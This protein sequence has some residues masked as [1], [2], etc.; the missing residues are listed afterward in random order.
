MKRIYT[1]LLVA[2]V[3][4]FGI[5]TTALAT[6]YS[7]TEATVIKA[8][9][10]GSGE[11]TNT[12]G[13][14]NFYNAEAT[15]W[16]C[17]QANISG[18]N[19][20]NQNAA[21]G[22]SY[23]VII[24]FNLS[25]AL[26]G[27]KIQ[28]AKL[29]FKSVCTVSGKNSNVIVSSIGT[30]W[31]A[32]TVTWNS[33][34]KAATQISAGNGQNV[35]TSTKTLTE[36][37][38][39][40]LTDDQDKVVAFAIYT[41][42]AREQ[43]ISDIKLTV[44]AI[45]E[46]SSANVKLLYVDASNGELKSETVVGTTGS[47]LTL[48]DAQKA[49]FFA[50]DKKYMYVSDNSADVTIASDGTSVITIS[51]REAETWTYT[52]NAVDGENTFLMKLISSTAYEAEKINV[53]YPA[54]INVEGA[55]WSTGK[56]YSNDGKGFQTSVTMSQDNVTKDLTYTKK[57]IENIVYFSE[58]ENIEGMTVCNTANA[59]V[60][61]SNAA[62]AFAPT[63]VTL[64][65]LP[66]GRYALYTVCYD[67]RKNPNSTWVFKAG[68][69]T[70]ATINCTTINY[71][72]A[73]AADF[74]ISKETDIIL[75]KG[76]NNSIGIDLI[77]IVKTGDV[78]VVTD[79]ND[80]TSY[81][82]NADLTGEG[83]FDATGT[84]G[85]SGGIVKVGNA[86]AFD[87]KQ[88]IANLPA[89]QYKVTAQAAYRFGADEA[90]EAAAITAGT[91]TKLVQLY[92]T[93][94][95]KTVT[96]KVQNRYDGASETDYANGN[97]SVTV[98]EKFVPNTSDAVKAW[99]AAGKY[100]NEVT[101]NL[102]ADGAVTIGINRT[103]TPESDYT[104]IGPWTLTRLGDAEVE[105]DP[106]KIA[107]SDFSKS[108]PL[109]GDLF[110]YGKDANGGAYGMQD[111]TEWNKVILNSNA[112]EGFEGSGLGGAV[113]AYG[114]TNLMRGNQKSAPAAGPNGE[115]GNSLGFFAVWG[116]GGYYYQDLKLAAGNYALRIPMY[117]QS[118]AQANES[119]TGFFVKDSDV[120]YT[121]PVNPTVGE[122]T[123]QSIIFT[124]TEE[125]EG[126][127]RL[128]YLST[129]NG[130]GANPMLF[131]DGVQL[132][133]IEDI[134][135][136]LKAEVATALE[137]KQSA[138]TK[139]ALET[140]LATFTAEQN[141]TN[142]EALKTALA[143]AKTSINSYKILETGIIPD[144]KLDGWTCTNTNTF[145]INT[146][147]GEGNSDG[148]NMKTPF[149][150]N[151][152]N[153]NDGFL[154]TGE[155]Y[156]SLPGLDP[157][158][159][160]FS[161]LIRAYSES[162]NE[163]TG[164]S[165]FAQNREKEFATGHNFVYN[166]MKGIYDTYTMSAEVGED[167][168]FKFGI[169][170][171]ETRNFNWMAFKNCRV[172]YVGAAITEEAVN[173]LATTM[174]EGKMNADVKK[175]AEDAVAAA[176]ATIGIETYE[177]AQV[178]IAAAKTSAEAYAAA[179]ETL[180][181]M[182]Q[183]TEETNVY[184]AEALASYYTQWTEKYEANTLTTEEAN[185]LQDP[186]A[187]TGW[188][189]DAN[190]K[191]DDLLLSAWSIGEAKAKDYE[192]S[193]YIN[194]WSTEG[195]NDGS[196]FKVPF[197]EYWTGDDNSLGENTLT[198]TMNGVEPGV[199]NVSAWVRVRAKN[200]YEAPV[201]GITLQAN[202][203]EA[204]DVAAGDQVGTSQFFL[205]EFTATGTVAED[206][207]LKIKFNVA[208]DNNASWLSF[209]NVKFEKK[210]ELIL[211]LK[212]PVGEETTL[213][214]G[215]YDAEDT[216]T[217]DFGGE[218]NVQTAKVGIDNKGP[219]KEDG[220]TGSATQ[221]KGTVGGDG[222]IKVYGLK[223]I[224][225]LITTNGAMPTTFDQPKLMNVV[226]MKITGADV[227]SV[228]LPAYPKMT[229]FDFN[230]SSAKSVD[231]TKVPT[232]TSLTINNTTSSKYAPQ[233]ESIDLSKNTE[234]T[235]LSLQ[236]NKDNYGKLTTLD[237]TANTKL[238]NLYVQFNAL[239]EVKLGEN[240][241]N[242]I[243]VQDNQLP[244]LD[245]TKLTGLKNIYASN[246]KLAGEA[247]LS[248]NAK[249]ENVQLNNNKLTSVKVSNATKQFYVDGNLLTL[250]TIP[251]QPAGMST[252]N[253]TKQFHYAPQAAM[254]VAETVSEL[255]LTSQLTVAKG[256]LNPEA[257]GEAAAYT[258]WLEN[259]TTTF[260]FITA[261][262]TVLVEGTD[263]E[264]TEPGKF[265]FLKAQAEKVHAVMLNA[266]FPK[267]TEAAPFTTTE[268]TVEAASGEE[269]EEVKVTYALKTDETHASADAVEVKNEDEVVATI[270]Y[271]EAGG[272]DFKAGKADAHVEGFEA[273]TEGNGT[274]GNNAGGTFYTIVPKFDGKIDV[275]VVLNAD[276]K[277]YI[278]EDGTALADFDGIT[279]SE[280][281]YGTFTFDVKAEK[282]YKIYA[283]G[284][285]LGFYGFNYTY[286][287]AKQPEVTELEL[288]LNV[289]RYTGMGYG[290]TEATVD[291][292]EAK[293]FLGVE[294]ITE[295]MLT[296]LNP[297]G[298]E[299][300]AKATDGWFNGEGVAETWG[301][302][303]K[304][305]VKFF[306]AIAG[307]G[308]YSICDMNGADEVG[309]TYS[310]KWQLAA[311]GKKVIYTI[312]VTFVEKPVITLTFA[313]LTKKDE[314]SVALTSELGR[315]YEGLTADVDVAAILAKLEVSSLN[316]VT[317]YAVQSNGSLDDNYKLGTTDGWRNA[318][319]D[320]QGW[321]NDAYFFVKAD[322]AKESAQIYEAGGMDGKNTTADWENPASYTATYAF[323][324]TGTT[325][326][327]VLKVT[328]TYTIPTGINAIATDAQKGVIYNM[329]G[330]K[331]N[332][333]KKGLFIINGKKTVVK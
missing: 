2:L 38:T 98:N 291:F 131:I 11:Y 16:L 158:I 311:N 155:I 212:A 329:N 284:T 78:E 106:S 316:D 235:Y 286:K 231:V 27:M 162:G 325:D 103:G 10:T 51:C 85:I 101:F 192:T 315:Y 121:V 211:T 167:G 202:E 307:E 191:V 81:I 5:Q 296:A 181:K 208:A 33:L 199:Y 210:P 271:G 179:N 268:F 176:K 161:A 327:V 138:K 127:I 225:Y 157:G 50:N 322:F 143:A 272:A 159:Y 317:I 12:N 189:H 185:A 304:I 171:A 147:S 313:D 241:L 100:V 314:Q 105:V 45:D 122:W 69:T 133:A 31:D 24:K 222:T 6:D 76:G 299:V 168:V 9:G 14:L 247:D 72:E 42:T 21:Y 118:G 256:E 48:T 65:K 227:E 195:N 203:G 228:T 41:Y 66:A 29:S 245:W 55:L 301:D 251:A 260:S 149:I 115:T 53:G 221:F 112:D 324:K 187:Q 289:E 54:Y 8:S 273:F 1:S 263:Y 22:G 292:T 190:M 129:G 79:P 302:N 148:S 182:K 153:K 200:G 35:A 321:G 128:G 323:V 58:G 333:A 77:Y 248:A 309:K 246:N 204:V 83:G 99:F 237:L 20:N 36:D 15:S 110:G 293:A 209:K 257:V 330:Q 207:V 160:S 320:W 84:K 126:Q 177:A 303:T 59:A 19:L 142:V 113:F 261:G 264:V 88:T 265:K 119:Y 124:L 306:E 86:S 236:G 226:Q 178:A 238:E 278:L 297:D 287:Q 123:V 217:V 102:P 43:K 39:S 186:Y 134:Y 96:T 93:V 89:G 288:T 114:S 254:Q 130:S 71:W 109:E 57:N 154:G 183:F 242:L 308:K 230:N 111:I 94:G 170:I 95:E 215:V 193:L 166:G 67:A 74:E 194:T 92:A 87:F 249:L 4:L 108:T 137:T 214:F 169:K 234:L 150:E 132:E 139:T 326:A 40:L 25:E 104:V 47:T 135:A 275:A 70:I 23:A 30:D 277:F 298:S 34:N 17:T 290:V 262:G 197:F 145:H 253:K 233:L 232:L 258:T 229:Q 279:V 280:K 219:V 255:D 56:N 244:S 213:T 152:C 266:A 259:Q 62:A 240:A 285:K 63:D 294:A 218:N 184:T 310:V 332:K 319:G 220:T 156:Y 295:D 331:V 174:P 163:P 328:L 97:G 91:D 125:T 205:K 175:A 300:A 305:N 173:E 136:D 216:F 26:A 64:T 18:G 49:S 198:A 120:K 318:A 151:W 276:K 270:T 188:Q 80:Y 223:D 283:A 107:N 144:D 250:A 267:F 224:W 68:D 172:A 28:D 60:R 46:S 282:A 75:E 73:P 146:W 3:A 180:A 13:D 82:T 196:N 37:V 164:A 140:A 201:K 206:G 281:K 312:N 61:S 243:N 44:E 252:K 274:N 239:T 117:N 52:L 116:C 165:L 90:A 269:F 7:P 141:E 32:T